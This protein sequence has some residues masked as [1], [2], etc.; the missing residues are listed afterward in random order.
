MSDEFSK[1]PTKSCYIA[2]WNR[3]CLSSL[4]F[5]LVSL[6]T[7]LKKRHHA[8]I[9]R[10]TIVITRPFGIAILLVEDNLYVQI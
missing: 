10:L 8:K 6:T 9:G 3:K 5:L 4:I 7:H 1:C 2:G